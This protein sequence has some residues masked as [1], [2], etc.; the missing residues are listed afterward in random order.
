MVTKYL[1]LLSISFFFSTALAHDCMELNPFDYGQ[2][3]MALGVGWT[4]EGCTYISG[5]DSINQEDENHSEYFFESM[6]ECENTCTTHDGILGDLNE[7]DTINV[8]DIVLL[9]NIILND[10]IPNNHIQWAADVN[11]DVIL[12]ILDVVILVNIIL[13]PLLNE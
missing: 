13:L 12:N 2:C 5:C 6:D 7:D 3:D 8:L 11:I 9:V 1:Y 4:A 10:I